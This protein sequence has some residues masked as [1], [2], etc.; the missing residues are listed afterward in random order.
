MDSICERALQKYRAE[1]KADAICVLCIDYRFVDSALGQIETD[2]GLK[3][4]LLTAPGAGLFTL[5]EEVV[6]P[7]YGKVFFE[8]LQIAI[9]LHHIETVVVFSHAN[10]GGYKKIFGDQCPVKE[11]KTHIISMSL[12]RKEIARLYPQLDFIGYFQHFDGQ[13]ERVL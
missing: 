13:I 1:Q 7:A 2:Y 5:H 12:L 8:T 3:F 10:C 6:G 11:R 9:D 4:D